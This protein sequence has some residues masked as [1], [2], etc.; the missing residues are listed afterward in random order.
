MR[1]CYHS[2]E[3]DGLISKGVLCD[4]QSQWKYDSGVVGGV[5]GG[6]V[7][8]AQKGRV[9]KGWS[10]RYYYLVPKWSFP[11]GCTRPIAP[12]NTTSYV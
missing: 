5:V 11:S 3:D 4:S 1:E 6:L 10:K 7:K 9:G 12:N 8:G 2:V